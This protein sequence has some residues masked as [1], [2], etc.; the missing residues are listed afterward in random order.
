MPF[1]MFVNKT[2]IVGIDTQS[3]CTV[4]IHHSLEGRDMN[5]EAGSG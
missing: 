3:C 5:T 1:I 4:S 2:R